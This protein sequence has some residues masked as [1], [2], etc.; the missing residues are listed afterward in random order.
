MT[1]MVARNNAGYSI[2]KTGGSPGRKE[3]FF[4]SGHGQGLYKMTMGES[5][6][7]DVAAEITD[8]K[9]LSKD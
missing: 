1:K 9:S 3:V 6:S 4:R 5:K 2:G 8:F 7:G